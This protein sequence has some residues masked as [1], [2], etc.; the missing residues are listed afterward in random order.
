MRPRTPPIELR[1]DVLRILDQTLLP[2]KTRYIETQDY[3]DVCDAIRTLAVRGAPLIGIAAAYGLALAMR[4]GDDSPAA[5]EQL[6]ATRPTAA[7]LCWALG[8]VL[9]AGDAAR[10]EREA[11]RIHDEQIASDAHCGELGADLLA[12]A[13][14]HHDALTVITHCNTGSLATGGIGTALGVVKTA[15]RRGSRLNVLVDE[16]RPLLQGT[17]LTAWELAQEG[18]EHQV[19]VDAA[20]AGFISR[21]GID[22]VIVGADRIAANGDVANK[23]GTYGLALAA[24]EHGVP[25]YIVAPTSTIDTHTSSGAA[26]TIEERAEDEVLGFG[27]QRAAPTGARALN[28][29]F[30]MTP[31]HLIAAI[32]TE[33]GVLRAPYAAAIAAVNT[34]PAVT[35]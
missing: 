32:V 5:A 15:H 17:R 11:R 16:T 23:V 14:S 10:A 28:P 3:R 29:A 34:A 9:K 35:V 12:S 1:D 8:R 7:N 6:T 13:A 22:A 19:I 30:D 27:T 24:R 20:A 21:G 26:I 31:S 2:H 4:R 25:F 33:L 18:I